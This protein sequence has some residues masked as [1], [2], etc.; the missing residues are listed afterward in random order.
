MTDRLTPSAVLQ[1]LQDN[2]GAPFAEVFR[3]G[4]LQVEIYKPDGGPEGGEASDV[5]HGR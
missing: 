3:H 1:Q 5:G 4:S 2:P